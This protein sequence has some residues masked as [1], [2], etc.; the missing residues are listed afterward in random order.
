[1]WGV[2]PYPTVGK[3][4]PL[5][6]ITAFFFLFFSFFS[7]LAFFFFFSRPSG[8]NAII[9]SQL[10]IDVTDTVS[11]FLSSPLSLSLLSSPALT[12]LYRPG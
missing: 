7:F 8:S 3:T 9:V 4:I 2:L 1:M 11:F 6:L 5:S 12:G 10:P